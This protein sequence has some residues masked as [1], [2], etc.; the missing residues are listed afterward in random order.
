MYKLIKAD[1][2][3]H[4]QLL[5]TEKV[6]QELSRFVQSEWRDIAIGKIM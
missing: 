4:Q 6:K 5:E 2:L 1:L 3:G